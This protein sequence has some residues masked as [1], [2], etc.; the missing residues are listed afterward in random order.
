MKPNVSYHSARL[1]GK[2]VRNFYRALL[3]KIIRR[4]LRVSRSLD[5]DVFAYSGE[6]SLPEQ[7]A[8]IRSFL[9]YAGR[10]KQFTVLSDGSYSA[11]SIALLERIED[12]VR[13]QQI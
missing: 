7:V 1:E 9:A 12:C 11:R 6:N 8:S 4:R 3:P 5:M 13:V 10:P 2:I